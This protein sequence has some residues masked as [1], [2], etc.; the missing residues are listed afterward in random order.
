ME[1]PNSNKL[2]YSKAQ[3]KDVKDYRLISLFEKSV[4]CG[5]RDCTII[6]SLFCGK[7]GME[8]LS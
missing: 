5:Q 6:V 3:V 1:V 4:S 8:I 2:L 7:K